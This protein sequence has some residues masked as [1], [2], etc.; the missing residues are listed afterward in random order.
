MPPTLDRLLN[1]D[2]KR[3]NVALLSLLLLGSSFA[4]LISGL[5]VVNRRCWV[6][7]CAHRHRGD[8]GEL[9]GLKIRSG[10]SLS[11]L[12]TNV[13][14]MYFAWWVLQLF[15]LN[16]EQTITSNRFIYLRGFSVALCIM[17]FQS[18][19]LWWEE[20]GT[21]AT[22]VHRGSQHINTPGTTATIP[23]VPLLHAIQSLSFFAS[24]NFLLSFVI[25]YFLYKFKDV[26]IGNNEYQEIASSSPEPNQDYNNEYEQELSRSTKSKRGKKKR[27]KRQN[28]Q[29]ERKKTST[30]TEDPEF[31]LNDDNPFDDDIGMEDL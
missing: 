23:N 12:L 13:V 26:L 28:R 6:V 14:C 8:K 24:L 20:S 16:S 31:G 10:D 21:V 25:A 17:L 22:F 7:P 1:L 19:Y 27:N 11:A 4:S 15:L 3:S 18:S 5:F 2:N 9:L 30:R 29:E